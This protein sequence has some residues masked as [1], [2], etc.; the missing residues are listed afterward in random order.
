MYPILQIQDFISS[1]AGSK[2]LSEVA[3]IWGYHQIPVAPGDICKTVISTPFG[4]LICQNANPPRE[5]WTPSYTALRSPCKSWWSAHGKWGCWRAPLPLTCI[6]HKTS[7]QWSFCQTWG[8]S[9]PPGWAQLLRPLCWHMWHQT[10]TFL[11]DITALSFLIPT[12]SDNF[13]DF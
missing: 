10:S 4:L 12:M 6:I 3:L 2:K 5:W 7:G 8:M 11:N 1:L 9:I 13:E